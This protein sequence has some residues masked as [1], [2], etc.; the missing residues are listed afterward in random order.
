[1]NTVTFCGPG[2][3][4]GCPISV[5]FVEPEPAR[6]LDLHEPRKWKETF[7]E[8]RQLIEFTRPWRP[9]PDRR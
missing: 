8:T 2:I 5:E 1:M 6:V 4:E 7:Y 9:A 3:V